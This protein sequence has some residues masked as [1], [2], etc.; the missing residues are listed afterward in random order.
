MGS[1][2]RGAICTSLD[3][4]RFARDIQLHNG[5][6]IDYNIAGEARNGDM[7]MQSHQVYNTK[8]WRDYSRYHALNSD[9]K[10]FFH[11]TLK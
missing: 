8:T 4:A 10:A 6:R 3:I 2:L 7:V 1:I 5:R 11:L 9:R